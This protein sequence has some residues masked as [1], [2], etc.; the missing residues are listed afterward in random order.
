MEDRLDIGDVARLTGLSVRALRFYEGRG[1]VAPLRTAGGRRI[2]GR[3]ELAQLN[4]AVAL[5]QAGATRLYDRMDEWQ[6][7]QSPP[8]N[9]AA[10]TFMKAASAARSGKAG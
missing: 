5:K 1:I 4:A 6:G 9:A 2:Y 3:G 8:F 10:W 7:E